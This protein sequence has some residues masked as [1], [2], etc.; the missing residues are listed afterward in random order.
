MPSWTRPLPAWLPGCPPALLSYLAFACL[1]ALVLHSSGRSPA[2]STCHELGIL[3]SIVVVRLLVVVVGY[4][5]RQDGTVYSS[6]W[7]AQH[8]LWLRLRLRL[9]LRYHKAERGGLCLGGYCMQAW[10]SFEHYV[11]LHKYEAQEAHNFINLM[12]DVFG[13][14]VEKVFRIWF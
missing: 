5:C 13:R 2:L 7:L 1:V 3:L 10:L 6:K 14:S 9:R 11:M 12:S 4:K 8:R